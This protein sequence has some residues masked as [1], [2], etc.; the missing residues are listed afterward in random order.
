MA[1]N[2]PPISVNS[3]PK[4]S[5]R[6]AFTL[7]EI[8]VTIALIG[9]ITA[10][11]VSQMGSGMPQAVVDTRL[12]ADVAHLN[13]MVAVYLADGGSLD[14]ITSEQ[15]VIDKLKRARPATESKT[16]IGVTTGRLVD[17][18]LRATLTANASTTRAVWNSTSKRFEI[19]TTG[20]V[21][22]FALDDSLAD[23]SFPL[24]TRSASRIKYNSSNG[25]VWGTSGA[26]PTIAYNPPTTANRVNQGNNF[27]PTIDLPSGTTAGTGTGPSTGTGP[28]T[29]TG[30]STGTGPGTT[31]TT[32]PTPTMNP[33]G[34]TFSAS[35]FPT[36]VTINNNGAPGGASS[37]VIYRK[38]GSGWMDYTGPVPLASGDRIEAMNLSLSAATYSDSAVNGQEYYSLINGFTGS[39]AGTW[40]DVVG[41]PALDY[42]IT[43]GSPTTSVSHGNTKLDLGNGE[44]LDAGVANVLGY[45][46]NDFSNIQP[47]VSFKLGNLN[48]LNGTT[49]Y[50]SEAS[51][52]KLR[53]NL[54]LT[55][56]PLNTTMDI[57]FNLVSTENSTDRLASADIV[58]IATPQPT[59]FTIDNVTYTL[60]L[61]WVTLDPGAGVVQGNQFLVFEGAAAQAELRATLY[62]NH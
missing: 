21:N 30:P 61:S 57:V 47:N 60:Q 32:L 59:S 20:G 9:V 42:E 28:G 22:T 41:G 18:R 49:F 8:F 17:V 36:S 34:G 62:S 40:T 24:D 51:S 10:V 33:L 23:A 26:D 7:L 45:T 5:S 19:G 56:P 13:Q 44:F 55:S 35:S 11:A 6:A 58:E 14:G 2:T 54:N 1:V 46:K 50:D 48:L 12:S 15:G 4:L 16:N 38:N 37:K 25:W 39:G 31:A 43:P 53:I 3:H 27:D 29:G 52:V